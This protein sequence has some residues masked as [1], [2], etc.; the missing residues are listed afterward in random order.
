[1]VDEYTRECLAI[2]VTGSIR[3]SRVIEVLAR[4][5]SVHG[6]SRYLHSDDGPEFVSRAILRCLQQTLLL[7]GTKLACQLVSYEVLA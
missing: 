4:L 1:M 5:I 3:F 7:S 6:A 2:D